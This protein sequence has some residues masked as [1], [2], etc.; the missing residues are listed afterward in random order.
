MFAE[1]AIYLPFRTLLILQ[2]DTKFSFFAHV[3]I[4]TRLDCTKRV[5]IE[6]ART[7]DYP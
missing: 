3:H 2:S 6:N 7:I 1:L 4:S 5:R